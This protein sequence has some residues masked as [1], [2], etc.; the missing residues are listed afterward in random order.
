MSSSDDTVLDPPH[1]LVISYRGRYDPGLAAEPSSRVSWLI[2][3]DADGVTLLTVV[4]DQLD[5][6]PK[7][8]EAAER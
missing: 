1:R 8:A 3:P 5:T 4:H 6:A 7:T 2:E